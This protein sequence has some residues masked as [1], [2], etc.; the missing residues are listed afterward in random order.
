[1]IHTHLS[2]SCYILGVITLPDQLHHHVIMHEVVVLC[3]SRLSSIGPDRSVIVTEDVNLGQICMFTRRRPLKHKKMRRAL[4]YVR[5]VKT[6]KLVDSVLT[7]HY[8]HYIT[9]LVS[10][11]STPQR[12]CRDYSKETACHLLPALGCAA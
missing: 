12:C 10:M 1:M 7:R 8:P 4:Q 5:Y 6:L 11:A 9:T 3:V 2:M